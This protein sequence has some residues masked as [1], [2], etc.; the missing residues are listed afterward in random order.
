MGGGGPHPISLYKGIG[1]APALHLEEALKD[2]CVQLTL[3][4]NS[5]SEQQSIAGDARRSLGG[6]VQINVQPAGGI[7]A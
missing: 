1:G 3:S 6:G 5:V 4:T 2:P 7:K